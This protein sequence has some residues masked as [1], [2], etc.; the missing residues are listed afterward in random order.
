MD[1]V[2]LL[3]IVVLQI[4][5]IWRPRVVNVSVSS[6]RADDPERWLRDVHRRLRRE[7]LPPDKEK[8]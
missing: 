4:Y 7:V 2:L 1:S 8:P 5:Q 6:V 3:M